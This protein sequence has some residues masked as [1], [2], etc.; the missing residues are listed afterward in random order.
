MSGAHEAV[1]HHDA[2]GVV[3]GFLFCNLLSM[4]ETLEGKQ[5]MR[6]AGLGVLFALYKLAVCGNRGTGRVYSDR[7]QEVSLGA[8]WRR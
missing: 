5:G 3:M 7:E 2:V 4:W 1:S 8:A 6:A